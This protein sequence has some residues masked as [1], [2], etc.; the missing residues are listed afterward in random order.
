MAKHGS[1]ITTISVSGPFTPYRGGIYAGCSN[2]KREHAVAVVGYGTENG[3]DYWLIKG[4]SYAVL[5]SSYIPLCR[6]PG[7]LGGGR[8]ATSGYREG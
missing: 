3:I 8:V 5:S 1:V 4:S 2:K 6:T 7:D